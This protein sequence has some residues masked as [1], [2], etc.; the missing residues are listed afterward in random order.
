MRTIIALL[1]LGWIFVACED[2]L[3]V[4]P[5]NS[6]TL[7]NAL[8]T[9]QDFES[10]IGG[11]EQ[12]LKYTII[13]NNPFMQEEKGEYIDEIAT[14]ISMSPL[15]NNYNSVEIVNYNTDTWTQYYDGI[16]FANVVLNQV[17]DAPMS[18]ERKNLYK[19]QALFFKAMFYYR[20]VQRWGDCVLVKDDVIVGPVAKTPW[21][22]VIAYA[23]EL[24]REA[25]K[26]LPE[27]DKMTNWKGEAYTHKA[28]PGKGAANALLAYLCAWQ[29][30]CKYFAN[31]PDYD[32]Q[33]LWEEAELACT[34]IIESGV[35]ELEADPEMVCTRGLV[36][37]SPESIFETLNRGFEYELDFTGLGNLISY[38]GGG[39]MGII[40]Y[41][42]NPG[43]GISSVKD[44]NYRIRVSTVN[45]WYGQGDKRKESFFYKPNEL[46]EQTGGYACFYKFRELWFDKVWGYMLGV[47]QNKIWW[48]LA[49][50]YLLRA[51]CRVRLGD[52]A[53]AIE[54]L[55]VVRDRAGAKRYEAS[56]NNGDLRYTVFLER[57]KEL[58]FEG[59]RYF[60]VI[61]NGYV[62][63]ELMGDFKTLSVQDMKDGALF[64][65]IENSQNTGAFTNNPLMRQNTYWF[66]RM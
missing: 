39:G 42:L 65:C 25:V 52:N 1:L 58:N 55:N 16:Q 21:N 28:A 3:N 26:C 24:A 32:E 11:V 20:I 64:M 60:D 14:Y 44:G 2:E 53:G 19:G 29:A 9:P 54:D 6:L 50:I 49:D 35:Y 38:V 31:E 7:A 61:R 12:N 41:P 18:S 46:A 48:R 37:N 47:D 45:A 23:I 4:L 66:R 22:E 34:E 30:G 8:T 40:G 13:Q 27:Y 43:I 51:E 62:N 56:E 33:V 59:H 15:L 36:G 63:T 57:Q 5:E 10:A 17:D